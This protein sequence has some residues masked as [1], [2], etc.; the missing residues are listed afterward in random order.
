VKKELAASFAALVYECE[1]NGYVAGVD[2]E[3]WA[4]CRAKVEALEAVHGKLVNKKQSIQRIRKEEEERSRELQERVYGVHRV[5]KFGAS[6]KKKAE[7]NKPWWEKAW[8]N[9]WDETRK[10]VTPDAALAGELEKKRILQRAHGPNAELSKSLTVEKTWQ[11][12]L[13]ENLCLTPDFVEKVKVHATYVD[14]RDVRA[15]EDDAARE[16]IGIIPSPTKE[17]TDDKPLV[18]EDLRKY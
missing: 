17:T 11:Q 6:L 8:D 2:P 9:A 10:A 5:N 12:K 4:E 3:L 1:V 7:A 13:I 15:H 18:L 16:I 14:V